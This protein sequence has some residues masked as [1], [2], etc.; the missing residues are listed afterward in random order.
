MTGV[1]C[2]AAELSARGYIVTVTA[3]NAPTV[4]L[5]ASTPD[6]KKTFNIQVKCN[7]PK[8]NKAFWLM[9]EAAKVAS[10]NLVYIF[11][12]LKEN[13]KPDFYITDSRT[14]SKNIGI[15]RRKNSIFYWFGRNAKYKDNWNVLK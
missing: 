12:N 14:V 10:P 9:S 13:A 7:K 1:Y 11:V 6:L 3:R 2:A 15:D 8:G 5:M 4:D